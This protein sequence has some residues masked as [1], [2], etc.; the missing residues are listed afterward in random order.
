MRRI[1]AAATA[2]LA[3]GAILLS[4]LVA[5][6]PAAA[7]EYAG[8][9]GDFGPAPAGGTGPWD[10]VID[11]DDGTVVLGKGVLRRFDAN[12][13]QDAAFGDVEIGTGLES[14]SVQILDDGTVSVLRRQPASASI[15]RVG[16]DGEPVA[17]FGDGGELSLPTSTI[18]HDVTQA[19]DGSIF[20]E[21][22]ATT[23]TVAVAR[24]DTTGQIDPSFGSA[25]TAS[26][27]CCG[28]GPLS[29]S[30]SGLIA[31]ADGT[32]DVL[33]SH[34]AG[35]AVFR[36]DGGDGAPIGSVNLPA[37]ATEHPLRLATLPDGSLL[38][39]GFDSSLPGS[40]GTLRRV[41]PDWTLDG[42]FGGSGLVAISSSDWNDPIVQPDRLVL[43]LGS[44]QSTE[45]IGVDASGID[46]T[47][48]TAG[49]VVMS[50][51]SS[52][53][54]VTYSA[55]MIRT[56]GLSG[57]Q[58][59]TIGTSS[60]LSVN[61]FE[62]PRRTVI[63]ERDA[64]GAEVYTAQ[65][66]EGW[67]G[68]VARRHDGSASIV[69]SAS[70]PVYTPMPATAYVARW[71]PTDPSAALG[72]VRSLAAVVEGTSGSVTWQGPAAVRGLRI[73]GYKARIVQPG[74][75]A[76][77]PSS[78]PSQLQLQLPQL[79]AGQAYRVE[80]RPVGLQGDG[81]LPNEPLIVI[82]HFASVPAFASQ[83]AADFGLPAPAAGDLATLTAALDAGS[84]E[85][86]FAVRAAAD[87]PTW[88][89]QLDPVIRLYSAY[90]G[91]LP[92][93]SGLRYWMARRAAGTPIARISAT[94]A[95]S[96]EFKRKYGS[97]TDRAF[98]ELV[99]QNVLGRAG[100][101]GGIAY[102]TRR[103]AMRTTSRGQLM[104]SF[105][106]SVE[107]LRRRDALVQTVGLYWGM[108]QRVPTPTEVQ[109]WT[110]PNPPGDEAALARTLLTSAEYLARLD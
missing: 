101:P 58:I 104:A 80:V 64:D 62:T 5:P 49:R 98:V 91:R 53:Y 10:I 90:F 70:A 34:E 42:G 84:V 31:N 37:S 107:H 47:F 97:L 51:P 65:S 110:G 39:S 96:S 29:L 23:T 73:E 25:G 48:G 89:N 16:S 56:V 38:V 43:V 2:G 17:S 15:L 33:V 63:T 59:L 108:L 79:M 36:I 86:E 106:E 94:F 102:W 52:L 46:A 8:F 35:G 22:P 20:V 92:D 77:L 55:R 72:P 32:V 87:G 45:L 82:P 50:S 12:G 6:H 26:L 24:Y 57:G 41:A 105:S 69:L 109:T 40:K 66:Q 61:Q 54:A 30:V 71:V 95:A 9:D 44:G 18:G 83:V 85:P 99:Y 78:T 88:R 13:T 100:D 3:A 11:G 21:Q 75:G 93:P 67:L 74:T 28:G 14:S 27:A 60:W 103:I 4:G 7:S 81:P 1:R 76:V 19:G 68:D